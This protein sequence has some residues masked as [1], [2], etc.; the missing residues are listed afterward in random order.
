MVLGTM[1]ALSVSSGAVTAQEERVQKVAAL[2]Q[3]GVIALKDGD[4]QLASACFREVLVIQ[5][6]HG[7]ARY[8]LLSLKDRKP[9]M[10][11]KMRQRKLAQIKIP[12][13]NFDESEFGEVIEALDI[14]ITKETKGGFAPNFV[15]QDPHGLLENKKITM[16]LGSVPANI[17]LDY[18]LKMANAKVR[19]DEHAIVI[20][21]IGKA[22]R[23]VE[24]DKGGLDK[25][26]VTDDPFAR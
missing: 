14:L 12:K 16:K 17:L 4:T 3:Q 18:V 7:N 21:P 1:L 8:Q 20:A 15:I 26:A 23:T 25:K 13:V 5:P 11:A 9:K 2:Y 24:V 19:Y 10:A 6:S 22:P